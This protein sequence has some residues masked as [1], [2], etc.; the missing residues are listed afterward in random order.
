MAVERSL[1]LVSRTQTLLLG[2]QQALSMELEDVNDA[3]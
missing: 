1:L 3:E 2:S